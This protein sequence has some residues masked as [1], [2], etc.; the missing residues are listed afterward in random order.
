QLG[1]FDVTA[2]AQFL[3]FLWIPDPRTP[4]AGAKTVEPGTF[5]RWSNG[6]LS[7][8]SYSSP[9]HPAVHTPRVKLAQ[10]AEEGSALLRGAIRRQL[11]SDVPIGLMASGG[12]D[13][14]LLWWGAG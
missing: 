13:S 12:I 2:L 10:A 9:L 11:L 5:L 3:T 1:Q 14:G 7:G 4:Y 6:R 8:D